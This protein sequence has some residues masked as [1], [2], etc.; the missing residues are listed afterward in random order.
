MLVPNRHESSESYRYGF[1]GKEK[2]DEL[3]GEGNSFDFGDRM[4]DP[5]T[6]RWFTR[7]PLEGKYPQ[8]S[9][10]SSMGNNPMFFIDADG[11]EP[12]PSYLGFVMSY[13]LLKLRPTQWYQTGGIYHKKSFNDA[14]LYSTE[15]LRYDAYRTV[16]QRNAYYAWVQKEADKKG[17]NSQWFGAAEIVTGYRAVGGTE[18]PDRGYFSSDEVDRFLQEGN[19]FLFERNMRNAKDL[20]DDGK[21]TKSFTDANGVRQS[22]EGLVGIDLDYKMVE[23]EQSK[24]QE[25]I[26]NYR[27]DLKKIIA[28]VNKLMSSP[29][30][31]SEVKK[32]MKEHFEGGKTFDFKRYRDRV[33]LGKELIKMAHDDK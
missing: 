20:L 4:Y 6:G 13:R 9:S 33:K 11:K 17:I 18:I 22:F 15:H 28:G 30:G 32:V 25:F 8:W 31:A 19:Q 26:K 3:K 12:V 21:L 2:D 1:N 10:Y 7:D 23:Y 29:I 5:R 16:R 24:V 27:G 14:A